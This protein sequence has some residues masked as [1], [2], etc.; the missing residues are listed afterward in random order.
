MT[1]WCNPDRLAQETSDVAMDQ[2]VH[3]ELTRTYDE[4]LGEAIPEMLIE[5]IRT[6]PAGSASH[7]GQELRSGS[8]GNWRA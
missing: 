2:W 8:S 7:T 1:N 4:V 6:W 5:L 3:R